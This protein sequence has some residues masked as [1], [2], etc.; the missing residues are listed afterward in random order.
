MRRAHSDRPQ[1]M[2][3]RAKAIGQNKESAAPFGATLSE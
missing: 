2:P 1:K 3:S